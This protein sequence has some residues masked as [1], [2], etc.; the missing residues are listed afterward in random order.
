MN[1]ERLYNIILAPVVSEKTT[2]LGDRVRQFA[3]RV[4]KNAT[5]QEIKKAIELIFKVEVN[6]VT[7]NHVKSKTK[8]FGRIMGTK[9]GW[10]KAYVT[11][12]EGHDIDFTSGE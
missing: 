12:K 1:N 6:S 9:S 3:F 10:K 11:L 7:T 5:K 8:R 2:M 4:M